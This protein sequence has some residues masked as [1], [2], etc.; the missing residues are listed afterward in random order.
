MATPQPVIPRPQKK[1]KAVASRGTFW[2]NKL[3]I[4]SSVFTL[5]LVWRTFSQRPPLFG[6]SAPP[7]STNPTC[8]VYHPDILQNC[9]DHRIFPG[10]SPWAL[11]SCDRGRREWSPSFG[12]YNLQ[13][14]EGELFL[15]NWRDTPEAVPLKLPFRG[16]VNAEGKTSNDF[17]PLGIAIAP[18]DDGK[19]RFFITNQAK[20]KALVEVVDFNPLGS[21]YEHIQTINNA[22]IH[23]PNGIVAL[24]AN[25]FFVTSDYMFARRWSPG[26]VVEGA[27]AL[28][29]GEVLYVALTKNAEGVR[30]SRVQLVSKASSPVGIE[31]DKD[32]KT[33]WVSSLSSGVYQFKYELEP[34]KTP[35]E[36]NDALFPLNFKAKEFI[37]SPIWPDNLVLTEDKRLLLSG[38]YKTE[39]YFTSMI[40]AQSRKPKSWTLELLPK[41]TKASLA[42][43]EGKKEM[44]LRHIDPANLALR[45]E[46]AR[47]RTVFWDDGSVYGGISTGTLVNYGPG[48]KPGF[49]GTSLV[50]DGAVLCK[51]HDTTVGGRGW[52]YKAHD[53]PGHA[54]G[55]A[56]GH[57]EL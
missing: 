29:F 39:E 26:V 9:E 55:E 3:T 27:L 21:S 40:N 28:P 24:D 36:W 31:L 23:S 38:V 11:L 14:P 57:S 20:R 18:L 34:K 32:S 6:V 53:E 22:R 48:K 54:K 13:A 5:S 19:F 2:A 25:H 56:A 4:V 16:A 12:Q 52:K 51:V 15:W 35:D 1:G 45:S 49:L 17:H 10:D 43:E 37:R 42:T 33:F 30:G 50:N 44:G 47:W 7:A 8:Q 41:L 46:E